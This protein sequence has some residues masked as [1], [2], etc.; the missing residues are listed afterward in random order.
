[1]LFLLPKLVDFVNI[2]KIE[3]EKNKEY[4]SD[5]YKINNFWQQ[6]QQVLILSNKTPKVLMCWL[7]LLRG[8]SSF[9][10]NSK[11]EKW[12]FFENSEKSKN[13][14]FFDNFWKRTL[15][16]IYVAV[17]IKSGNSKPPSSANWCIFSYSLFL[18]IWCILCTHSMTW[19]NHFCVKVSILEIQEISI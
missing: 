6:K 5:I 7:M 4:F 15:C 14:Q 13:E 10:R 17:N 1:M 11:N 19:R 2:W 9:L 8:P 12:R 3:I 16:S 18:H